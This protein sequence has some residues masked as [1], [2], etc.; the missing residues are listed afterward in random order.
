MNAHDRNSSDF[1]HRGQRITLPLPSSLAP[2]AGDR[3]YIRLIDHPRAWN[4]PAR[5]LSVDACG[6]AEL[7]P[8]GAVKQPRDWRIVPPG[9]VES[10][11]APYEEISNYVPQFDLFAGL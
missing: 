8:G 11:R 10:D 7:E 4:M 2:R 1:A 5:V 9:A 3:V 6:L